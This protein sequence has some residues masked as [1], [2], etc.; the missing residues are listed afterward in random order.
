ML[1][2]RG[3]VDKSG[4]QVASVVAAL[5]LFLLW[6]YLANFAGLVKP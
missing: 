2:F 4:W 5:V 3:P 6:R 1:R